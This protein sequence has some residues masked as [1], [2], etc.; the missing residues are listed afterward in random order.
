M[1][2]LLVTVAPL[3]IVRLPPC[4][5]ARRTG[6]LIITSLV[7]LMVTS[8]TLHSEAVEPQAPLKGADSQAIRPS[9]VYVVAK[10]S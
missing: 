4:K 7:E 10:A 8:R 2:A 6:E 9:K 1:P 5:T 3:L